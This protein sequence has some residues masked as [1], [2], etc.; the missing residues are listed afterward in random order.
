VSKFLLLLT[1]FDQNKYVMAVC[2]VYEVTQ[3]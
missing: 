2:E 1:T 3:I